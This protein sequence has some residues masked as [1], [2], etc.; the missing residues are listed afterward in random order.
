MDKNTIFPS[1]KT[2]RFRNRIITIEK[3]YNNGYFKHHSRLVL[4]W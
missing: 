4:F 1:K 3:A 2:I